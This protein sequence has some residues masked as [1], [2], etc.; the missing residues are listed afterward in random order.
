M[1]NID[2]SMVV[3]SEQSEQQKLSEARAGMKCSRLQGR[4]VLGEATCAAIDAIAEDPETPWAMR[5]TIT[6]A[7]EWQR[8]SQS[9]VELAWVLGFTDEEM[10][11]LFQTAMTVEV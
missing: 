6:N 1:S 3:T 8:T 5:Q 11:T 4:L 7:I 9:M 2:T 10:D